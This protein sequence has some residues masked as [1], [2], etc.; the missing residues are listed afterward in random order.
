MTCDEIT[1]LLPEY[2]IGELPDETSRKVHDHMLS[3]PDCT[4]RFARIQSVARRISMGPFGPP[5]DAYFSRFPGMVMEK[6]DTSTTAP[7]AHARFRNVRRALLAAAAVGAAAALLVFTVWHAG[8]FSGPGTAAHPSPGAGPAVVAPPI[9]DELSR[10]IASLDFSGTDDT[11]TLLFGDEPWEAL[12]DIS[13]TEWIEVLS[14][15][16]QENS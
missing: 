8:P 4:A 3:C 10:E 7:R 9:D 13:D 2:L 6:I 15:L 1:R 5:D 12:P 11:L 14:E 16:S